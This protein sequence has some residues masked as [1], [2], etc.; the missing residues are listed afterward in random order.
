MKRLFIWGIIMAAG[1]LSGCPAEELYELSIEGHTFRVEIADTPEERQRGLMERTELG[2]DRGMLFIFSEDRKL[3]F[4]MKNTLLPLSIA[5]IDSEG[6]IREIHS[7]TPLSLQPIPSRTSV[8]YALEVEQG[9]FD[10]LGIEEGDR[11]I[12]WEERPAAGE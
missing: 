8:R 4:W 3:S 10:E 11:V 9:R 5:Y 7:M 1:L 2:E 6:I 12:F